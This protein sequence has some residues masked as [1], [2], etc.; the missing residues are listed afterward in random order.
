VLRRRKFSAAHFALRER[1]QP[2]LGGKGTPTAC[3]NSANC[4]LQGLSGLG[5][6]CAVRDGNMCLC[7]ASE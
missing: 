1:G 3:D 5:A 2:A 6:V 7:R 4:M